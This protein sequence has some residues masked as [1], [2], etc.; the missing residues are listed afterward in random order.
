ME[1]EKRERVERERERERERL[2]NSYTARE[3]ELRLKSE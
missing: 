2:F 1:R 3:R